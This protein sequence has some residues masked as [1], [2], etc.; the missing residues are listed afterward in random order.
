MSN[1]NKQQAKNALE[2]IKTALRVGNENQ[3]ITLVQQIF[4]AGFQHGVNSIFDG[5]PEDEEMI[6]KQF[7]SNNHE[8]EKIKLAHCQSRDP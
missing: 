6:Q 3:A 8:T 2:R 4:E 7:K 1:L 5:S